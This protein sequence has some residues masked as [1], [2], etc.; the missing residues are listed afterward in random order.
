MP[1]AALLVGCIRFVLRPWWT[2]ADNIHCCW[3]RLCWAM[4]LHLAKHTFA[5]IKPAP[6]C[7]QVPFPVREAVFDLV[8]KNRYRFFGRS[9]C[10]QVSLWQGRRQGLLFCCA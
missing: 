7:P 5:D 3:R 9:D 1:Q 6:C 4:D 2:A 10:C 8:A